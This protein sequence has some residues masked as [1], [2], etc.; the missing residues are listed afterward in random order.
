MADKTTFRLGT[1]TSIPIRLDIQ[2][3]AIVANNVAQILCHTTQTF[4]TL[5]ANSQ[6]APTGAALIFTCKKNGSVVVTGTITVGTNSTITVTWASGS[7]FSVVAGD[8]LSFN[9]TQVG[10]LVSGGN[11]LLITL[12]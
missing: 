4:T 9:I 11:D 3:T 7:S 12:S 5:I 8:V 1:S 2:G 6:T 10:S